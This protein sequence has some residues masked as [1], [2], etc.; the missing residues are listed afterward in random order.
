ML[1]RGHAARTA[2]AA[3]AL[4]PAPVPAGPKTAITVASTPI[5]SCATVLSIPQLAFM[6]ERIVVEG[7]L[8]AAMQLALAAIAPD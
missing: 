2:R 3:H 1:V 4:R 7:D 5:A 6:T 8:R